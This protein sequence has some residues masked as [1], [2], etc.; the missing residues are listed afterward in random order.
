MILKVYD[1][2]DDGREE[3]ERKRAEKILERVQSGVQS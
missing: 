2:V 3:K 1:S